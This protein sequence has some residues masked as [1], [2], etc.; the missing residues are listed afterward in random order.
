M[1]Q[2]ILNAI[3]DNV[4]YHDYESKLEQDVLNNTEHQIEYFRLRDMKI[5]HCTGC[6]NCWWKTPG[7][8]AIKDEH[9]QILSRFPH[10]D[11]VIFVSPVIMGYETAMLKTCKDRIV[12]TAMPYIEIYK[13]EMHH[14]QRYN[15]SPDFEIRLLTDAETT[16]GDINVIRNTY[17]RIALNFHSK[18][19]GLT[20][21]EVTGG[22]ELVLNCI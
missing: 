4:V 22:E 15:S 3:P 11:R 18:V 13:G 21:T 5:G 6:W 19:V 16:S 1:K 20:T 14:V 9:E 2:L 17:E 12:P 8:C 10:V 7:L